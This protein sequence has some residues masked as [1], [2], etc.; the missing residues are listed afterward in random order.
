MIAISRWGMLAAALVAC[1]GCADRGPSAPAAQRGDLRDDASDDD[2]DVVRVPGDRAV[3]A[4]N[5][6]GIGRTVTPT[7]KIDTDN[8]FFRSIGINGR[9][10]V[11]CHVASQGWTVTPEG[12]SERFERTNGLD[13][14]FRTNDGSNS[15]LAD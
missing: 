2:S 8:L 11:S 3:L 12:L 15:P 5:E 6:T 13:P 10:C 1:A 4:A 14:V 7:G 9:A